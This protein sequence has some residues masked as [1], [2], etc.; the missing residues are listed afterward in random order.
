M[1]DETNNENVVD[2]NSKK[3]NLEEVESIFKFNSRMEELKLEVLKLLDEHT[4]KDLI[5]PEILDKRTLT[6]NR[7]FSDMMLTTNMMQMMGKKR[8]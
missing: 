7:L 2:I 1:N 5:P 6:I 4:P 8:K 3:K